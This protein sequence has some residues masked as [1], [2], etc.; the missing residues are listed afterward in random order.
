MGEAVRQGWVQ[1]HTAQLLTHPLVALGAAHQAVHHRRLTH[2]IGHAQARVERGERVLEDHLHLQPGSLARRRVQV[3]QALAVP[4]HLARAGRMQARHHARQ[5]GLAAARLAHQPD[6]LALAHL[7]VHAVD[8]VHRLLAHGAAQ[9]T[10]DAPRQVQ[11]LHEALGDAA[12]LQHGRGYGVTTRRAGWATLRA[13]ALRDERLRAARR[14]HANGSS[15]GWW[16]H[17]RWPGSGS[18]GTGRCWQAGPA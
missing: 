17:R 12:Q 4:A 13:V 18:D 15:T 9:R 3:L 7:Q 6:H 14:A 5:R 8:R 16:H 11:A 2:Q 1:A 10:G